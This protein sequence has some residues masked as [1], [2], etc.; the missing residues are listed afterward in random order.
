MS[1]SMPTCKSK[2]SNTPSSA[3][4]AI[5]MPRS[6]LNSTT[7]EHRWTDQ[8]PGG[9]LAEDGR[10][11]QALSDLGCQPS[12]CQQH[13]QEIEQQAGEIQPLGSRS[14]HASRL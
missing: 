8:N 2:R 5:Q 12:G 3:I 1:I 10:H 6:P 4:T 13:D 14:N 9:D 7:P 11:P